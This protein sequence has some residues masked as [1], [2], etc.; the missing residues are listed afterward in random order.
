LTPKLKAK[1]QSEISISTHIYKSINK[2]KSIARCQDTI[3]YLSLHLCLYQYKLLSGH[4]VFALSKEKTHGKLQKK[5]LIGR[6]KSKTKQ[7]RK[8]L[9][10]C[11]VDKREKK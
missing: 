3:E 9:I 8:I 7:E 2:S 5:I 11:E 10:R 4:I 6:N 1:S